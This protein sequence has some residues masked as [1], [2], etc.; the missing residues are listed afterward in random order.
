MMTTTRTDIGIQEDVLTELELDARVQPNEV[1]V[2]VKGG[3]VTLLGTVD[4]YFK[5]N[6]A[7]E[8]ALRVNGVKAVDNELEIRLP[9]PAEPTDEDIAQAIAHAL[10]CNA[11]IPR[12]AIDASVSHGYVTLK[13]QVAWYYQ[14]K[15]VER[16]AREVTGVRGATNLIGVRQRVIPIDVEHKIEAALVR[17]AETHAQ[18]I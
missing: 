7:E 10:E 3:V 14:R 11:S 15:A 6:A 16:E 1:G 17:S 12:E 2:R 8:A 18:R 13:G 9:G 4:S 5:R